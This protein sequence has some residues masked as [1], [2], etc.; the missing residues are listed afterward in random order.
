MPGAG[1][2][3][4]GRGRRSVPPHP[5]LPAHAG[6]RG[7]R[8]GEVRHRQPH[9]QAPEPVHGRR[10]VRHRHEARGAGARTVGRPDEGPRPERRAGPQPAAVDSRRV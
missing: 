2:P 6:G 5:P 1:P 7:F 3:R 8:L 9:P 10:P 4:Q